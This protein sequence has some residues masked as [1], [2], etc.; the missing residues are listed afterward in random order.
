MSHAW[1]FTGPPGSGRS[2]AAVAFAAAL[3]CPD[4]GC[5][6]CHE[7]HTVA[8]RH[9]CRRRP[10]AHPEAVDRRRRG[11]RPRAPRR[12]RPGRTPL[13]DPDHR[14]RRPAHRAGVQRPAQG[15]RGADRPHRLDALHTQRRGRPAH[16][17]LAL[18]PG[19]AVD[20]H[21]GPGGQLPDPHRR[22]ERGV[23]RLRRPRQPGPHRPS[24]RARSRR[25]HPQPASRDRVAAAA[26][27]LARRVHAGRHQPR[28]GRQGGGRR[29]HLRARP[30]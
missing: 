2:N 10:G 28:R 8:G 14:G 20:A 21:G 17:P 24:A 9:P 11:A 3:Q 26:A 13:A 4:Q 23:G 16:D 12:S 15:H 29:H 30:G 27:H 22:R 7:C 19:R 1:L 18:P 25:G 6:T 5:G